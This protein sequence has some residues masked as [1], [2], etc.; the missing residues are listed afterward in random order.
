MSQSNNTADGDLPLAD[1]LNERPTTRNPN[2]FALE[3]PE[4]PTVADLTPT[5][6]AIRLALVYDGPLTLKALSE[7]TLLST[8]TVRYALKQMADEGAIRSWENPDDG[9]QNVYAL[10][11]GH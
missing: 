4:T 8:R 10:T 3:L 2:E 5:C 11:E 1:L 6:K 9:R 7:V